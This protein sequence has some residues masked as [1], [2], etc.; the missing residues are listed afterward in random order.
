MIVSRNNYADYYL[1]CGGSGTPWSQCLGQRLGDHARVPAGEITNP[2]RQLIDAGQ[3]G[4]A[5]S[6]LFPSESDAAVA[7]RFC[8]FNVVRHAKVTQRRSRLSF[9]E[10]LSEVQ[11]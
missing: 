1:S 10:T 11:R 2:D 8:G 3:S 9:R 4:N 7:C 5:F 6:S